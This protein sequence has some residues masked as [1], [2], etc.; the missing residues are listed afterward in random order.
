LH[1]EV[2]EI[3]P[4]LRSIVRITHLLILNEILNI[5]M[6]SKVAKK[7]IINQSYLK[8]EVH[9]LKSSG[10]LKSSSGTI[11]PFIPCL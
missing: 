10:H 8:I 4:S 1:V 7:N 11:G 3:S 5:I 6:L 9:I 2:L